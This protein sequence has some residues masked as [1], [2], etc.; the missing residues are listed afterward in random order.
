MGLTQ[1][2]PLSLS[3]LA[4]LLECLCTFPLPTSGDWH[5]SPKRKSGTTPDFPI[6]HTTGSQGEIRK[7]ILFFWQRTPLGPI[8]LSAWPL[9]SANTDCISR[10]AQWLKTPQWGARWPA[11]P[12]RIHNVLACLQ[13]VISKPHAMANHWG[14]P[15]SL[16]QGRMFRERDKLL[17]AHTVM[18]SARVWRDDIRVQTIKFT[19]FPLCK[20]KHTVMY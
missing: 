1:S 5:I 12:I 19:H 11:L 16:E 8:H 20:W 10:K 13:R 14:R 3:S 17:I 7:H 18:S 4:H 9:R 15:E 6:K 2:Y